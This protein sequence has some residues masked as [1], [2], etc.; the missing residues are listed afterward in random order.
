MGG[1]V[2]KYSRINQEVWRIAARYSSYLRDEE[3][4]LCKIA[5]PDIDQEISFLSSRVKDANEWDRKKLL[6]VTSFLKGTKNDVLT[7]KADDTNTLTL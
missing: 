2:A 6:T 7:L 5:Q 4:F 1:N 3:M